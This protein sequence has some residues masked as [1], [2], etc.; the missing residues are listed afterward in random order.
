MFEK[1]LRE[2]KFMASASSEVDLDRYRWTLTK[3][4]RGDTCAAASRA[5]QEIWSRLLIF[6]LT[7]KAAA[8]V[9]VFNLG[10]NAE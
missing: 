10:D 2:N 3:N 7:L 8:E 1:F 4:I 5:S 9:A 6:C